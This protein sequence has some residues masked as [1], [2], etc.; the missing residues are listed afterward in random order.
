MANGVKWIKI[1]TDIFD[2]EKI[3]L[4]EQ[5]PEHDSII[6]IWFK[7][8][9]LA[10]KQNNCGVFMFQST[11]PYTDEM[12]AAIFRRPLNTVR[13]SLDT[14]ERFG[15][16]ERINGA[17]TIPNWEKHQSLD[18]LEK[19]R[20]DGRRRFSEYK[21]RQKALAEKDANVSTN[22]SAN[23]SLTA[24]NATDI[25]GEKEE[26]IDKEPDK[27][28]SGEPINLARHSAKRHK[29]GEYKNVL[30]DDRSLDIWQHEC[31]EWQ[32]YIEKMSNYCARTGKKYGN[33]LA[34]L[35]NWYRRDHEQPE[36]KTYEE[37]A[38]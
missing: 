8:L 17:V 4:I 36:T 32:E 30:L 34:A 2:D 5:M 38:Y 37:A 31:P 26:E 11:M 3:L 9:T 28:E 22:V 15:M 23:V 16:I 1:V 21:A 6:V 29:Y 27:S 12:F 35:R 25:E 33:Y 7:L 13:L 18:K 10:G 14:F 24:T 19:I 20:A